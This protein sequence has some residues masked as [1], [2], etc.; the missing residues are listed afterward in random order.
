MKMVL[1]SQSHI[2]LKK[3][4]QEIII[5]CSEIIIPLGS[6]WTNIENVP[7]YIIIYNHDVKRLEINKH[8]HTSFK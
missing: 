2:Y 6:C 1:K 7:M 3:T 5:I 8:T 4:V